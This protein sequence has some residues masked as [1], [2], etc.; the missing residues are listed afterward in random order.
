LSFCYKGFVRENVDVAV[1]V[2]R[3]MAVLTPCVVN[4]VGAEGKVIPKLTMDLDEH[5]EQAVSISFNQ[6]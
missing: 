2:R 3:M 5:F 1:C 6:F 4:R